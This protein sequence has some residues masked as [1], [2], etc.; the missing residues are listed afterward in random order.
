MLFFSRLSFCSVLVCFSVPCSVFVYCSSVIVISSCYVSL[1]FQPF[2]PFIRWRAYFTL[3]L[4]AACP[5]FILFTRSH[6][7]TPHKTLLFNP[8]RA[9]V[10]STTRWR[11]I[12]LPYFRYSPILVR[13]SSLWCSQY[14]AEVFNPFEP[15]P[16]DT[17]TAVPGFPQF[18]RSFV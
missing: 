5:L 11:G 2:R 14:W 12:W 1:L 10:A 13:I 16:H 9:I 8:L 6:F 18:T 3:I 7:V 17:F 15:S 4:G